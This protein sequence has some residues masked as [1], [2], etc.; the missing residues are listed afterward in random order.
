MDGRVFRAPLPFLF[1]LLFPAGLAKADAVNAEW[2]STT[3]SLGMGNVGIASAED[4]TTAVFYNPAAITRSKKSGVEFFNPQFDFGTG[5]FSMSPL[6]TDWAKHA[7]YLASKPLLFKKP[8]AI[9]SLGFSLF[10]NFTA[11]WVSVGVLARTHRWS[12]YDKENFTYHSYSRT[13]LMPTMTL[14]ASLLGGRL[15]LGAAA[16]I[17]QISKS[18]GEETTSAAT[19]TLAT[20]TGLGMGFDGGVLITLP[21]Q[22]LPTIGGVARNIGGTKFPKAGASLGGAVGTV[23]KHEKI[24]MSFD[25][26]FAL[27]PKLGRQSLMTLAFDYRDVTNTTKVTMMR[28]FNAGMEIAMSKKVYIRGGMSQGY[29]TA[30][31]GLASKEGAFDFGTY[32]DELHAT[33]FNVIENRKISFRFTRRF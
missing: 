10:P 9:S 30:G 18:E 5:M 22:W 27:T 19:T 2:V 29:W 32:A 14:A 13:I 15:R 26:G 20:E 23:T 8:G 12:Y 21:W 25:A 31:F 7:T 33:K 3:R 1:L 16:R 24:L 28:H 17:I 11:R 6:I 4:P